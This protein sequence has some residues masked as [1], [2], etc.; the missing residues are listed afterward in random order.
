LQAFLDQLRLPFQALTIG[1]FKLILQRGPEIEKD[2]IEVWGD[3]S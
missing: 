1:F 3:I 2:Q